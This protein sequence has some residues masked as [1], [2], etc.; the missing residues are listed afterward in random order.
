MGMFVLKAKPIKAGRILLAIS[1][2]LTAT[3]ALSGTL[4]QAAPERAESEAMSNAPGQLRR[5]E[6]FPRG[7]QV[8]RQRCASCH[9]AGV[10]RA[11]QRVV[12][13]FMTPRTI[14]E[15]LTSGSMKA[16]SYGLSDQDKI[17]VAQ[18]LSGHALEP[19]AET[20]EQA[21]CQGE[22]ALFDR[23]Q[24][25]AFEGW[26]FDM[27]G[28]HSIDAERAGIGKDNAA[29]L[30]L[31]W[32][33]GFPGAVRARS[34][35]ALGAGAIFVGSQ[36]GAVY[37]L[38]RETGCVRWQFKAGAEVRTGIVLESWKAGDEDAQP[39]AFFGDWAGN[40]YAVKA[41]TGELAWKVKVD[42]HPAAVTTGTPALHEGLLYVPVSSLEEASAA[43]PSYTCC[44][45]RGSVLALDAATGEER[46]RTY[47]V[48]EPQRHEGEDG[49]KAYYGPSGVAVWTAPLIDAKRGVLYVTTGDNYT[50]PATELSDAI[51]ALDLESGE[52]KWHFQATE[53]DAWNVACVTPAPVNC[54]EDA[55]PDFD[56]G[57]APLL[58]KGKDGREY[59]LAGQKSGIV[60]AVDPDSGK[61]IWQERLGRGG[62]AGGVHF[63]IAASNGRLIAPISDLPDGMPSDF[64]LSPG[65]FAVEIASGKRLW[66]APSP[67]IC[68]DRKLCIPGYAAAVTAT[69]DLVFAGSD[70]AYMRIFDAETGELVWEFDTAREFETVN[71]VEARGGAISGGAAPIVLDGEMILLSG[72]GF[73][74]K[75]PGNV[76]L[77]FEA[78]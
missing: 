76:M 24:T 10:G 70:D 37:A 61:L 48:D 27:A 7:A 17:E 75:R 20:Q 77:V 9:E 32:A 73:G 36:S 18:H 71:G 40:T 1:A 25:P 69:P 64:P 68:S 14:Y 23:S 16:M 5:V 51:V 12:I 33:F 59:L 57:A 58:A 15:A 65:I 26:G 13:G 11:P 55:G 46:W 53:G 21:T 41:F 78:E 30:K 4:L 28:T 67:D 49:A 72:Y 42:E 45:F 2:V 38:D 56:F 35:P 19:T 39:L 34:Q 43:D 6:P 60:Y 74:S 3:V 22:R 66:E 63:G 47:L 31:K 52:V 44:K 29:N 62:A 8:Y 50:Q 54:P